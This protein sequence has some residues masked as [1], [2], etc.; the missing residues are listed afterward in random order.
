MNNQFNI[1]K[2]RINQKI[3]II[4]LVVLLGAA[5]PLFATESTTDPPINTPDNAVLIVM[6]QNRQSFTVDLNTPVTK[7]Y[8]D[9]TRDFYGLIGILTII[10]LAYWL[11]EHETKKSTYCHPTADQNHRCLHCQHNSNIPKRLG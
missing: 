1:T 11:V 4:L 8:N 6:D 7:I 2:T 3:A 9:G 5:Q 10:T